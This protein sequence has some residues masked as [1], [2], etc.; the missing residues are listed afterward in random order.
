MAGRRLLGNPY[1]WAAAVAVVALPAMRPFLRHV[2]APPSRESTLP[3]FKLLTQDGRP[4]ENRHLKGHVFVVSLLATRCHAP[5]PDVTRAMRALQDRLD[6]HGAPVKLLSITFDPADDTPARLRAYAS[7]HGAD[8]GRWTFLTGEPAAV[9]R[10]LL[11]GFG[12]DPPGRG[13]D[14]A[15]SGVIDISHAGILFIVDGGGGIRGRYR[16]DAP[17]IDEV[18]H[19]SQHVLKQQRDHSPREG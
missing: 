2:P 14:G 1:V 6:R 5:C 10:L 13:G 4:F 17:G 19:R 16:P 12:A 11:E 7:G 15:K 18:F 3:S 9:R 8:P